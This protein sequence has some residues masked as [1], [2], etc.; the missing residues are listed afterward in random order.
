VSKWF[1]AQH[2]AQAKRALN[3][4]SGELVRSWKDAGGAARAGKLTL[5]KSNLGL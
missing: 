1:A 2:P 4:K 3:R 5:A